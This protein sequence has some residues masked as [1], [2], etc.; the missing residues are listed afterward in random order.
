MIV[1]LSA[2]FLFD[3]FRCDKIENDQRDATGNEHA[4]EIH[5][6][7]HVQVAMEIHSD[8]QADAHENREKTPFEAGKGICLKPL[9]DWF[10]FEI[11]RIESFFDHD[12][13]LFV[14][15]V[16]VYDEH[17]RCTAKE[18]NGDKEFA[19]H[20][21]SGTE[22]RKLMFDGGFSNFDQSFGRRVS[23]EG[24]AVKM[25]KLHT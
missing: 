15:V 23:A 20:D 14:P 7:L 11:E 2:L 6:I 3:F 16:E 10:S 17:P 4:S 12:H 13:A 24:Q 1:K 8:H 18:K 5:G 19:V 9:L 25:T 21:A 22:F